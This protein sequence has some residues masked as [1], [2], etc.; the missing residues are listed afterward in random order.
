[1][2]SF[3]FLFPE[4]SQG[5]DRFVIAAFLGLL[6]LLLSGMYFSF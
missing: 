6:S 2:F 1:M 5:H 4:N 3:F